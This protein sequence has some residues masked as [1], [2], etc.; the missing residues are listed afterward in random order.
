MHKLTWSLKKENEKRDV[1]VFSQIYGVKGVKRFQTRI[2]TSYA[3]SVYKSVKPVYALSFKLFVSCFVN[4]MKRL[5][6]RRK[7]ILKQLLFSHKVRYVPKPNSFQ[8]AFKLR[9]NILSIDWSYF[10]ELLQYVRNILLYFRKGMGGGRLN[11]SPC[12]CSIC[13]Y[14]KTRIMFIGKTRFITFV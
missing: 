14:L 13:L 1:R 4:A 7:A 2:E 11:K 3:A 6:S 8:N 12:Q 9:R 5:F 10:Y